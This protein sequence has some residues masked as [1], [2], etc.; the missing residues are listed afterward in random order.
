[1]TEDELIEQVA[2]AWR[3]PAIGDELRYHPSWHDL[4]AAG[5]VRAFDR[6]RALR[7][8]EAALDPDQLSTTA[9]AILA[10]IT[11]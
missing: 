6:T 11:P 3:P 10:K 5:R 1:M 2:S 7:A 8:A 9:R 4:D